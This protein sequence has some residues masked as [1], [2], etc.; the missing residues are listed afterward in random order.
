MTDETATVFK[1][2]P[3]IRALG[4]MIDSEEDSLSF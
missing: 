3:C 1:V 2:S 4:Q